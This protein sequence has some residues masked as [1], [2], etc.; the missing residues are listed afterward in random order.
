MKKRVSYITLLLFVLTV[1]QVNAQ[2]A[3]SLLVQANS[4]YNQG[5]YDSAI[6]FYNRVLDKKVE[7]AALYY[8]LGNAWFKKGEVP[9]AILYYEKA[10]K[11]SPDD[12]DIKYNLGVANSMIVDKIETV[13]KLFFQVWWRYFYDLF[14]ANQWAVILLVSWTLLVLF[15]GIFALSRSRRN[16]KA[17]F[18]LGLLFL[19]LTVASYGLASQKY[20]HAVLHN[21]AI[22]FTPTITVKSSPTQNAVDLFVIHEGTKVKILDKVDNWV[23]IKISNGSIGWIPQQSV[24]EI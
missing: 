16:K 23:K 20:H 3:D 19:L 15:F 2:T 5:L 8:N 18:F 17:G 6:N 7:S 10:K 21:E 12:E 1:F 4:A 13:P 11:L 14:G 22:V 9:H 24:E